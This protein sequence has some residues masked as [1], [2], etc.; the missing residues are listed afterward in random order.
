MLMLTSASLNGPWLNS[1]PG[2]STGRTRASLRA[3]LFTP[4]SIMNRSFKD[5]E[6][7]I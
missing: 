2:M 4:H 3:T 7:V 1:V 5:I 6:M